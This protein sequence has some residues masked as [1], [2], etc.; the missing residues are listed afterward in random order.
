M[1]LFLKQLVGT[2][3]IVCCLYRL[4]QS[5]LAW[6]NFTTEWSLRQQ[7]CLLRYCWWWWWWHQQKIDCTIIY[8]HIWCRSQCLLT[9]S[10]T[11]Y[12]K[13]W[14][15]MKIDHVIWK[16]VCVMLLKG[17]GKIL[18]RKMDETPVAMTI[19]FVKQLHNE[20][21]L[22]NSTRCSQNMWMK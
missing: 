18:F 16:Y 7:C 12:T 1:K 21:A 20:I 6:L 11:R 17:D 4:M 19:M 2:Y 5:V 14:N 3:Q 10:Y 8:G 13:L 9:H 22:V 15:L